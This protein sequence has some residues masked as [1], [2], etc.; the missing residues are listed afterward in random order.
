MN[1]EAMTWL[2]MI[3][4]PCWAIVGVIRSVLMA[5]KRPWQIPFGQTVLGETVLAQTVLCETVLG[6]SALGDTRLGQL[7]FDYRPL[8]AVVPVTALIIVGS[9]SMSPSWQQTTWLPCPP[10]Q[11]DCSRPVSG[12]AVPVKA[13]RAMKSA[14]AESI[15]RTPRQN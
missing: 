14:S 4:L 6:K 7:L 1:V 8:L 2:V 13:L 10:S 3:G 12:A 5:P 9:L 15:G 11:A